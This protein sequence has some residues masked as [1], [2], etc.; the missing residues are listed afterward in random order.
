MHT[1]H[2]ITSHY[3]T[4]FFSTLLCFAFLYITREI[5]VAT[6]IY[7]YILEMQIYV[8]LPF[9]VTYMY[10]KILNIQTFRSQNTR[11]FVFV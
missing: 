4:L 2:C 5:Q 9:V 1:L 6:D 8:C 7:P 10:C 11:T 3:L